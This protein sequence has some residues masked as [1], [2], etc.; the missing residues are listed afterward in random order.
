[1]KDKITIQDIEK[2]LRELEAKRPKT[3]FL[4]YCLT[5]DKILNY[6]DLNNLKLCNDT[7]C[8]SCRTFLNA[9]NEYGRDKGPSC[10]H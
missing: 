2:T 4:M 9:I 1:M 5:E 7:N 6:A 10:F 3:K 8:S